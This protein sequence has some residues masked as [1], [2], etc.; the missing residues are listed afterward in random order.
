M[1]HI[2]VSAEFEMHE[3]EMGSAVWTLGGS[4][5][6]ADTLNINESFQLGVR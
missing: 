6:A 1:C 4:Y 2:S 3:V 5:S